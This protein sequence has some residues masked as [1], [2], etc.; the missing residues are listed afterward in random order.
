MVATAI[1]AIGVGV[2]LYGAISGSEAADQQAQ[3]QSQALALQKQEMAER[4]KAMELDARRRRREIIR[5]GIAARSAAL[6]TSTA[7]GAQFS[8]ALPGAYGGIEGRSGTNL[9]GVNQNQEIGER[10]FDLKGLQSDAYVRAAMAGSNVATNQAM[11]QAGGMLINNSTQ[12][13]QLGRSAY[14]F[15]TS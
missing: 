5:Q 6:A 1:A 13:A 8:S 3:Y 10:I 12:L 4:R 7:Q 11:T 14:G 15:L 2:G 9:Q